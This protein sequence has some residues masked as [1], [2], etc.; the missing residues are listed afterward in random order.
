MPCLRLSRFRHAVIVAL[1]LLLLG[2]SSVQSSAK[3]SEYDTRAQP[4]ENDKPA[5][6]H[7]NESSEALPGHGG[8]LI[9]VLCTSSGLTFALVSGLL[10]RTVP[11]AYAS[12][13]INGALAIGTAYGVYLIAE[14]TEDLRWA[15][16]LAAPS[17]L[18]FSALTYYNFR[19]AKSHTP[20]RKFWINFSTTAVLTMAYSIFFVAMDQPRRGPGSDKTAENRFQFNVGAS[21]VGLEYRF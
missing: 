16:P 1:I 10:S 20:N 21:W 2:A 13:T 5:S 12:G 4:V 17:F 3:A 19:F 6:T 18:T 11:G 9:T 14:A 15:I 7:S 8:G